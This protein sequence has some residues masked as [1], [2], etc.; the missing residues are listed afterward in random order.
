MQQGFDIEEDSSA[1]G[2]LR[3]ERTFADPKD[4]KIA[5]LV[6]ITLDVASSCPA[7]SLLTAAASEKTVL[8]REVHKYDHFLFILPIPTGRE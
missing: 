6:R 2:L 8:N 5:Y 3:G 1:D 4:S 7:S